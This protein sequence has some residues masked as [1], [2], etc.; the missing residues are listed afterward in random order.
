MAA[1]LLF[2]CSKFPAFKKFKNVPDKLAGCHIFRHGYLLQ[3][4][5]GML[6]DTGA[7]ADAR[8]FPLHVFLFWDEVEK[9]AAAHPRLPLTTKVNFR[10]GGDTWAQ[11]GRHHKP[12]IFMAGSNSLGFRMTGEP[13]S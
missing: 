10:D 3:K 2:C 1:G 7:Y 6:F 11:T 12:A 8:G 9:I 13:H 5:K 4:S